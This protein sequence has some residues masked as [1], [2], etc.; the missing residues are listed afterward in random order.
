[1]LSDALSELLHTAASS[2]IVLELTEH[3]GVEDYTA[4]ELALRRLRSTGV[5]LAVDDA[6]A[7]FASLRHSLNLRPD[8]IKLDIDLVRGIDADPAR[9]ALAGSLLIFAG[10]IGAQVVAK[11][12]KPPPNAR[13]WICSVPSTARAITSAVPHPFLPLLWA[14]RLAARRWAQAW[15]PAPDPKSGPDVEHATQPC[16]R[17]QSQHPRRA[18]GQCQRGAGPV[19]AAVPLD[20]RRQAGGVHVGAIITEVDDDFLGPCRKSLLEPLR[21]GRQRS[22][23]QAALHVDHDTGPA[24]GRARAPDSDAVEATAGTGVMARP[25][26]V[27]AAPPGRQRLECGVVDMPVRCVP[28]VTVA[29]RTS[30]AVTVGR[31][32]ARRVSGTAGRWRNVAL[33]GRGRTRMAEQLP[34]VVGHGCELQADV[35]A[36]AGGLAPRDPARHVDETSLDRE[37]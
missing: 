8:I 5:R 25:Y 33:F 34:V 19:R 30:V 6:G 27:R 20:E 1:M 26:C 18:A 28:Y 3:V 15:A 7:G 21:N 9:R 35:D 36:L 17:Q 32:R 31:R 4:L 14:C 24:S 2:R 16:Q 10:E 12:S 29:R 23:V 22:T 13:S 37:R 11:A